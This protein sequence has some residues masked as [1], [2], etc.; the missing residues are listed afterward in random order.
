M[1]RRR[2]SR[3]RTSFS[4]KTNRKKRPFTRT[5]QDT[6]QTNHCSMT[7]VILAVDILP[8]ANTSQQEIQSADVRFS[9]LWF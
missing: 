4:C 3:Y 1:D 5:Y 7:E 9:S 6:L 8:L 2:L